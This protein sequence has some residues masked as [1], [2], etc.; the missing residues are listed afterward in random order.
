MDADDWTPT[1][2]HGVLDAA[3]ARHGPACRVFHYVDEG[4]D[5]TLGDVKT[6]ADRWA[7]ALATAGVEFGDRVAVFLQGHSSW[8]VLQVACSQLGAVLV[9]I[10]TRYRSHEIDHLL[11]VMQAKIVI[12]GPPWRGIDFMGMLEASIHRLLSEGRLSAQPVVVSADDEQSFLAAAHSGAGTGCTR[13]AVTPHDVAL[14]QFTSGSTAAPKGVR[15]THDAILRAAAYL[16]RA[17][18]FEPDDVIYSALPFYH[19]GGSI[20]TG[21]VALITGATMVIPETFE[22]VSALRHNLSARCT[23]HQGHAAMFT[24]FL[25]AARDA[26]EL[27]QLRIRKGW[28]AAPPS[29]MRRIINEIHADAF[30]PVYGMSEH[31]LATV[32]AT[33]DPV[34]KRIETVGRPGPGVSLRIDTDQPG[35]VGEIQLRSSML[36]KGYHG[37]ADASRAALTPDGWLQTGDLGRLDEDGFLIFV[38]RLKEMLKPGGENVSTREVEEFLMTHPGVAN[39]AVFGAPDD[40]LG[41]VPVAVVQGRP[42][43]ELSPDDVLEFCAGRIAGFKTPKRVH[44][45]S[46]MPLLPNGKMDKVTLRMTYS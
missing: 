26:G 13:R 33:T 46:D 20:C 9:G 19:I 44:V 4:V 2:L 41:E 35:G 24:M 42:G 25:D 37:A 39:A 11:A 7:S 31:P 23:G 45:V 30:V 27:K 3:I 32:C 22:A 29:V 28:A 21:P 5:L 43:G 36:M 40:R 10:N 12:S 16:S 14:I 17:T 6:R 8:P 15:L 1:T 38:D 18:A 34:E